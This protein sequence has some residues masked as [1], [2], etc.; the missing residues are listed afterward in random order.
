MTRNTAVAAALLTALSMPAAAQRGPAPT[1]TNLPGDILHVACGAK[2]A[3]ELPDRSLRVTGGQESFARR[4]WSPG[5]LI[6]IN[7]GSENG[8]EVGQ[9]YF[10]RRI[11]VENNSKVTRETPGSVRTAGWIKVYAVEKQMALATITHACDSIEVNDYLEPFV[12][13]T[14]PAAATE[15]LKPE[16]DNYARIMF[17]TDQ[18][19]A[20]GKG[21]LFI[22]D[23]GSDHG[24]KPGERFAVYRDKN[25]DQNFLYHLGEA[26][27]IE[28]SAETA[29][30]QVTLSR[31]AF[32]SG[33][34]V[35]ARKVPPTP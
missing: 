16:R 15:R 10:V 32:M 6:T 9:E 23:R 29:T 19:R 4:T 26:V 18:R 13:P 5:D 3:Y 11:Q 17:G 2:V 21:D 34:Y 27:A 1:K 20:F 14:I 31:D 30:L 28:V 24:I 8:I 12:L 25:V 35:A 7:G 22:I 33:D